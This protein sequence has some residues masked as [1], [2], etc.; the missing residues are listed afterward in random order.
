MRNKLVLALI[1]LGAVAVTT[2][3]ASM[4]QKARSLSQKLSVPYCNCAVQEGG[5]LY[6]FGM[7][8]S[9]RTECLFDVVC[10]IPDE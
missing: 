7:W 9:S 1:L 8:D 6:H 2:A 4:P 5:N 10:I 3:S